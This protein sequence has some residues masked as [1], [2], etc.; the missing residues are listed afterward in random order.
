MSALIGWGC[1][2]CIGIAVVILIPG[3]QPAG[4]CILLGAGL[5]MLIGEASER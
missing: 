5:G 1:G 2:M 3:T 4:A